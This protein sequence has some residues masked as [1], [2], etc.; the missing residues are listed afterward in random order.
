ML[1]RNDGIAVTAIRPRSF[2]K[3]SIRLRPTS[4][5]SL[6]IYIVEKDDVGYQRQ[7][8]ALQQALQ[9]YGTDNALGITVCSEFMLNYIF[10]HKAARMALLPL[11]SSRRKLP[12]STDARRYEH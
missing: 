1:S 2:R 9:T 6:A 12:I 5:S 4:K 7:K 8:T 11:L 3:R 10:E